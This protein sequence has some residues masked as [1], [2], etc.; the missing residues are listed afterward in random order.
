MKSVTNKEETKDIKN[1]KSKIKSKENVQGKSSKTTKRTSVKTK[2]IKT[3]NSESA[4]SK[5]NKTSKKANTQNTKDKTNSSTTVQ[6]NVTNSQLS[7]KTNEVILSNE[8]TQIKKDTNS[9]SSVKTITGLSSREVQDRIDKGLI[10]YNEEPK[11]KTVKDIVKSNVFTYFNFLNI[12]LGSLV[13]I[14]GIISGRILYSL[15]NCLFVNVIFINTLISIGEEILAKKTI[16][17]LSIIAESKIKVVRD[18]NIIELTKEDLVLD[19]VCLYTIGNQIVCDSIVLDGEIE[20][21]ESFITGEEKVITKKKGEELTS[22]SFVVSGSCFAKVEHI[23]SDNYVSKITKESKYIKETNS[24]IYNSFNKMLKVLSAL[25]IPIGILLFINQMNITYSFSDSIMNTVSAL[26][27]MIPEGLVLLTSSAMAVSVIRLRKY[28]IL[29]QDLYSIESLAR[30][31]IICLDKTGTIT[32]GNMEVKDII[33]YKNNSIDNIKEILGNYINALEDPT[34]TFKAIEAYVE[35]RY[36][37]KVEE[38]LNFSSSRKY[39]A[40]RFEDVTYFLGSPENLCNKEFEEVNKY[41]DDY[42]VLLLA[43][44]KNIG[45]TS[46]LKPIG[47]VLIQD[48]VKENAKE[49]LDYFK[50]QGVDIKIISGDSAKTV[51]SI[52][53]RAGIEDIKCIDMSKIDILD[54]TNIVNDYNIFAR[55]RPDQKKQIIKILKSQGHFVAMTGDGVNDCMALKEADCSIAMANGSEAAKN[56]SKFVLLDSKIDNLPK[57][58]KEGRRSINNIERSSSLLLSKTIFTILLILAC[59]YLNTEYFFIPIHLTLITTFTI[60]IPSFI[61]ALEPNTD[62][63]KGN[64]LQKIFLTSVPSALTV[65]FNVVIIK[66]FELNFGLSSELCSTLTVFLTATTGFIFL[67]NI[68][69]PYNLLRGTLMAFLLIAFGYCAIFQYNFFNISLVNSE[70]ILVFIVLFICSLFIFD[71]LKG[72]MDY[73]LKKTNNV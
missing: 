12:L 67:N 33:P 3:E 62:L 35:K 13:I 64:F 73:L 57:I 65:V 27:G 5:S 45:N 7:S 21:N 43:S 48:K 51:S 22:G 46:N 32:E 4:R 23:G 25:L 11:T 72:F 39:S 2:T 26:I 58:L 55:V 8:E 18:N 6:K 70:T 42:R 9:A 54:I 53:K 41:Q 59:I 36:G 52:A 31:D 63:V 24:I 60:G 56:V 28:N 16:D 44:G 61:L 71:K 47:F 15:K 69:K 49:V 66:L 1:K 14:S 29:V 30:V 19:D 38:K 17:K 50:E 20:I 68:C 37:Y 34:P 40:V 10:N